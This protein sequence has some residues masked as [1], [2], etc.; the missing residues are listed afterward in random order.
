M[1]PSDV[2]NTKQSQ[3]YWFFLKF[4]GND[5]YHYVDPLRKITTYVNYLDPKYT[6]IKLQTLTSQEKYHKIKSLEID[7]HALTELPDK[8]PDNLEYL[9][10]INNQ[11]TKLP[12]LPPKLKYLDITG[13]S[14]K[15]LPEQLPDMLEELHIGYTDISKLPSRL[16]SR[17]KILY[18]TG[19]PL[20]DDEIEKHQIAKFEFLFHKVRGKD[21]G[22]TKNTVHAFKSYLAPQPSNEFPKRKENTKMN[23]VVELDV[24]QLS[25]NMIDADTSS[26]EEEEGKEGKEGKEGESILIKPLD[27]EPLDC[28]DISDGE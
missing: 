3:K 28:W 13:N 9:S 15:N 16:P 22:S 20:E 8:L 6:K 2:V 18:C 5:Q 12:I 27:D 19:S 17:L 21:K 11:L 26:D 24:N 4:I 25:I 23:K 10:C 7:G 1:D 14:I